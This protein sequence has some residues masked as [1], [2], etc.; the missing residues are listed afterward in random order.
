MKKCI[1][2]Y[3]VF[4]PNIRSKSR[5]E[6]CLE[7]AKR[8]SKKYREKAVKN[9]MCIGCGKE[10]ENK[11]FKKCLKCLKKHCLESKIRQEKAKLNGI[12]RRCLALPKKYDGICEDCWFKIKASMHLN[13]PT[14]FLELKELLKKQD[15]KC[16]YTGKNI[17]P[18]LNASLDHKIPPKKGGTKTLDNVHWVDL[19]INYV[20]RNLSHKEFI[21]LCK[22]V[23][24][25]LGTY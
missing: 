2:C 15:F 8:A 9:G 18:G 1:D 12:C 13:D 19:D 16:V 6:N 21:D 17:F 7:K 24:S 4:T 20:K 10:K 23:N 14:K 3:K 22:L 11:K 5:C 25:R